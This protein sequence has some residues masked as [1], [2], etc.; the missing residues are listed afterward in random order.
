MSAGGGPGG[1]G[2][3]GGRGGRGGGGGAGG[4][5]TLRAELARSEQRLTALATALG[6]IAG[7]MEAGRRPAALA[8]MHLADS[9]HDVVNESLAAAGRLARDD[10]L[11]REQALERA[12][13]GSRRV[14]A[15]WLVLGLLLVA[16]ALVI[17]RRRIDR[18]LHDLEA[19]LARVADGDLTVQT[20]VHRADEIGRLAE[21][22]NQVTRVLRDRAEEQGRF[23]AAGELLA[24]VAH[25]VNN[26]LMAIAAH[27]ENRL[28]DATITDEARLEMQSI[29]RQARRASKLL[30]GLLRFVRAGEKRAAHVNLNDVVRS[31]IDLVSYR[32]TVNEISI[33]GRRD[34]NLA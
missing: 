31:A 13:V 28:A 24:G 21:H 19:G 12:T 5:D 11:Q 26:P 25:E 10:L 9:L 6:D 2:G 34:A 32:F 17:A 14:L 7:L 8:R 20:P 15:A 1:P 16:L 33:A 23:A 3:P 29:L 30:R 27:A 22:F 4:P 18:P